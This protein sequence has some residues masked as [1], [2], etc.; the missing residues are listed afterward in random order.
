MAALT[1]TRGALRSGCCVKDFTSVA[2]LSL[3]KRHFIGPNCDY[4]VLCLSTV[5]FTVG[6]ANHICCG[7]ESIVSSQKYDA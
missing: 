1:D 7:T 3:T 5:Y 2:P 6:S 4:E